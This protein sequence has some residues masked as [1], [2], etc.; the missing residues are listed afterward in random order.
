MM[1][2]EASEDSSTFLFRIC[3]RNSTNGTRL[4]GKLLRAGIEASSVYPFTLL[5]WETL[6]SSHTEESHW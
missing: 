5:S 2:I 6:F 4:N 3:D 1:Y